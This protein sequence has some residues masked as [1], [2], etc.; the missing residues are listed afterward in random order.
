MQ[1]LVQ[2]AWSIF[3]IGIKYMEPILILFLSIIGGLVCIVIVVKIIN[4]VGK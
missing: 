4:C 2:F 1:Y 3:I